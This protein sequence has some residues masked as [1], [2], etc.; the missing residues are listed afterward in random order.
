[1]GKNISTRLPVG[2]ENNQRVG[3]VSTTARKIFF[4]LR[5]YFVEFKTFYLENKRICH[6]L[7]YPELISLYPRPLDTTTDFKYPLF[8]LS[9]ELFCWGFHIIIFWNEKILINLPGF[10]TISSNSKLCFSLGKIISV[11]F[12]FLFMYL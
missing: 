7:E 8:P 2:V 10:V 6:Q 3:N 5:K 4:L 9:A 12:L 11:L 1:M